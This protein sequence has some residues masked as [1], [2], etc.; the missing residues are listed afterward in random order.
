MTWRKTSEGPV[1]TRVRN[2]V[3]TRGPSDFGPRPDLRA[4]EVLRDEAGEG[5]MLRNIANVKHAILVRV[6]E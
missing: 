5:V 3:P 1:S 6:G 2:A 4:T